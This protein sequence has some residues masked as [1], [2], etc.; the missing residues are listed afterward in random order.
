MPALMART[1]ASDKGCV[2]STPLASAANTGCRGFS[3]SVMGSLHLDLRFRHDFPPALHLALD[4]RVELFRTRGDDLQPVFLRPLLDLRAG[5]CL[6]RVRLD[7][8]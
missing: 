1:S 5:E 7:L 2:R 4:E 6:R 3:F 8:V